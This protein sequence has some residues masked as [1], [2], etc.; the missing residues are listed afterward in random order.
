MEIGHFRGGLHGGYLVDSSFLR[1]A[2]YNS[3]VHFCDDTS[4]NK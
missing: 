1:C 4:M 2:K 3:T